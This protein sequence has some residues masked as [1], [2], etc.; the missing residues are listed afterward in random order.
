MGEDV[1]PFG[2]Y[3]RREAERRFLLAAE[4][5]G[6]PA[7]A[8]ITDRYLDGTWLRIRHVVGP[9]GSVAMKLGQKLRTDPGDPSTVWLTN[10]YL[11][12]VEYGLLAVLPGGEVRKVRRHWETPAGRFSVDVFEG[13]LAG[14]VLAEV[15]CGDAGDLA[16]VAPPPGAVADVT[17]DDRFSGGRLARLR[18]G[19]L[20][21]LLAQWS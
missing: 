11:S 4:P 12:A 9:D 15:E 20:A 13:A 16:G 7:G 5:E 18:S 8:V 14:L 21:V 19:D 1:G 10:I 6:L 3:A 2:K 17:Y